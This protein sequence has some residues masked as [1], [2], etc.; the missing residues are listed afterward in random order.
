MSNI[1]PDINP[2]ELSD[3]PSPGEIRAGM[4]VVGSDGID[5]G[6]VKAAR[7]NDFVLDRPQGPDMYVPYDACWKITDGSV[8]V[9]RIPID[10]LT[11]QGWQ[12]ADDRAASA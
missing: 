4:K 7:E 6:R 8:V 5:T 12:T 11:H 2:E 3:R 10:V 1:G 9:L